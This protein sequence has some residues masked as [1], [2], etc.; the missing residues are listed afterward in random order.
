MRGETALYFLLFYRL[1]WIFQGEGGGGFGT[2]LTTVP[3]GSYDQ[4][5]V[6]APAYCGRGVGPGDKLTLDRTPCW[7]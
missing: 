7:P 3:L 5:L 4:G 2:Q 1:R 6:A